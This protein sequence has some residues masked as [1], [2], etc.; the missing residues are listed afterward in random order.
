ML[1]HQRR[2]THLIPRSK[3]QAHSTS[4]GGQ[5]LLWYADPEGKA[6]PGKNWSMVID[7]SDTSE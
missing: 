3:I 6:I 7:G 4:Q 2:S 5:I 1:R